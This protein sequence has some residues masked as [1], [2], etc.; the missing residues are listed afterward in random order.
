MFREKIYDEPVYR[1]DEELSRDIELFER[2]AWK[3]INNAVPE[4]ARNML[5]MHTYRKDDAEFTVIP[6][7]D[8]PAINKVV[9]LGLD[10][11]ITF[12]KLE[13]VT[14]FVVEQN[15]K[16]FF[17][18]LSPYV[19]TKKCNTILEYF[20]FRYYNDW[21]KLY[22]DN[23]SINLT[24]GVFNIKRVEE[25]HSELFGSLFTKIF[26]LPG[27]MSEWIIP[28]IGR[29]NWMHYIAWKD[30]TPAGI[31]TV[32]IS[33]GFVW[34]G[35]GGIL[36]EYRGTGGQLELLVRRI[37]D[38][39]KVGVRTMILE[40]AVDKLEKPS[41]SY[42]NVVKAGFKTAYFRPNYMFIS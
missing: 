8:K 15:V 24:E 42:R 19:L 1:K 29:E 7:I 40:T 30:R 38:A 2:E 18:Q 35:F 21:V 12:E 32:Y 9:G 39:K 14:D 26:E 41:Y 36:P 17:I 6:M 23:S 33:D 3:D 4:P 20:S 27:E 22:R 31:G 13:S 25:N 11:G 28:S 34:L 16:R 37:N 10:S 5:G